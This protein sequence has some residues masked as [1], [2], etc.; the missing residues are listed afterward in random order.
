MFALSLPAQL[1]PAPLVPAL[2]HLKNHSK[3]DGKKRRRASARRD[4][5]K[6]RFGERAHS[7]EG[8]PEAATT[9]D[10]EVVARRGAREARVARMVY[11]EA[12]DQIRSGARRF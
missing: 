8:P 11:A 12:A 9:V 4:E 1:L 10:A 6:A 5:V 2:F 7:A 3:H